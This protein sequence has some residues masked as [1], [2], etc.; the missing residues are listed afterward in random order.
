MNGELFWRASD[1]CWPSIQK[2]TVGPWVIRK[3]GSGGSRVSS[4]TPIGEYSKEDISLAEREM[5]ALGQ[6]NIFQIR[7]KDKD[8]DF[9]LSKKGYSLVDKTLIY[10]CN[11]G[12]ISCLTVP[13]VTAF[14][15]WPPLSIMEIIWGKAGI[16]GGRLSVMRRCD[17]KKTTILGRM[18]NK[19]AGC[20]FVSQSDG[21]AIIQSMF[22]LPKYR[23]KG[24]ARNILIEA[25]KWGLKE[26]SSYLALMTGK[27]NKEARALYDGLGMKVLE[28]YHYRVK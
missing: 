18:E 16:T 2:K 8:L 11:I 10:T 19:A 24:L 26:G 14:N 5:H 20:A 13:P 27:Y 12:E 3:G 23:R 21:I 6:S 15:I 1:I 4:T 7:R 9:L 28:S 25:A 17:V 22:V